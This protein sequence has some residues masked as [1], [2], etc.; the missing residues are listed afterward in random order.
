[1]GGKPYPVFKNFYAGGIGTV[2]GYNGS[3]LGPHDPGTGDP[4]GGN[5][6]LFANA[7]LQLP[8]GGGTDQSLRWFTFFDAGNVY[9]P[10]QEIK[11]LKLRSSIGL[12]ISW[13]S[14]LGPLKFS[15]GKPLRQQPSDN[16]QRLQF[17]IGTGF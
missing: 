16:V 2:R 1:L 7:E 9:G 15:Y 4:I 8:F 14:P 5:K 13:V 17:Q 3:S 10:G 12:G 11:P 6:R